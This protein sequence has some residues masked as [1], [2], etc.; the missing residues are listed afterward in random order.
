MTSFKNLIYTAFIISL[1]FSCE[2]DSDTNFILKGN[3]K[4]LKK[5]VLYLQKDGKSTIIN[6]DSVVVKGEPNFELKAN[7]EEPVLLYLK[8]QKNDGQEHYIPFFADKGITEINTTLKGFSSAAKIKGSKQQVVLEAYQELMTDFKNKNL[9]LLKANFEAVKRKD[10]T[11]TDSLYKQSERL[12][13]LKYASIINYALNNKDSEV[14]PY[15]A[16]Y[17]IP[18]TSA[19]YLDS[20][21]NNLKPD[22]KASIYGKKLGK[23]LSDF[24]IAQGSIK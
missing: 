2:N 6:L 20:I 12:L 14:A 8:L 5:G 15:L 23:V 16:L 24:K 22:I 19:K 17:E 1:F 10:T 13:R 21:Y 4:N 7:I 9:D 3:V 18:N 11:T